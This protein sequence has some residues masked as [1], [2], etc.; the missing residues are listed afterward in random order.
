M[1]KALFGLIICLFFVSCSSEDTFQERSSGLPDAVQKE[2]GQLP[3][4]VKD[5]MIFPSTLLSDKYDVE[6]GFS[7]SPPNDI[8][9]DIILTDFRY[10]GIDETW[11]I[12]LVT[13]H[14]TEEAMQ[15]KNETV[16]LDNGF[17]GNYR[18]NK[19]GLE[20]SVTW[21]DS[22]KKAQHEIFLLE[23]PSNDKPVYS[24]ADFLEVV[25]SFD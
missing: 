18:E 6:F 24:K 15:E 3:D 23:D 2:I 13:Y 20:R 11:T 9:G 16:E 22:D 21:N 19:N 1:K 7:S 17:K 8:H 25:N 5:A 14:G 12:H 10:G 4:D